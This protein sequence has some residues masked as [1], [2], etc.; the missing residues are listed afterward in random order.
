MRCTVA[1]LFDGIKSRI[2]TH[3]SFYTNRVHDGWVGVNLPARPY[4]V[5][6]L[7]GDARVATRLSQRFDELGGQAVIKGVGDTAGAARNVMKQ[8]FD[9][10]HNHPFEITGYKV[11]LLRVASLDVDVDTTVTTPG[12]NTHPFVG[13]DLYNIYADAIPIPPPEDDD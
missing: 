10:L 2:E 6:Q 12:T 7:P 4:I 13:I 11:T 5:A 3:N 8:L 9:A 1:D